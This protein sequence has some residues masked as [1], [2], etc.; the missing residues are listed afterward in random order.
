MRDMIPAA[1]IAAL[2]V[3]VV[4]Q[5]ERGPDAH[6]VRPQ[7]GDVIDVRGEPAPACAKRAG[8][9]YV[10][11]YRGWRYKPVAVGDRL[12]RAF[13]GTR[14]VIA[15][16]ARYRLPAAGGNRRWIRYGGDAV[17]VDARTGR[18][19]QVLANRCW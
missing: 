15:R 9:G 11:P 7:R 6:I 18:V 14:Y 2:A 19:L 5:T 8:S 16:P 13:Y 12:K 4:A 3:P 17:L 1:L 10:A